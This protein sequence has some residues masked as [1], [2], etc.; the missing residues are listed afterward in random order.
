[1]TPNPYLVKQN[2]LFCQI[3]TSAATT[4]S[5]YLEMFSSGASAQ[6]THTPRGVGGDARSAVKKQNQHEHIHC[7]QVGIKQFLNMET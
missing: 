7:L 3:L 6:Q 2:F 5:N 1:M 4:T